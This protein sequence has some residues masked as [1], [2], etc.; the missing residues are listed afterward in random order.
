MQIFNMR[1]CQIANLKELKTLKFP[2]IKSLNVLGNPGADELGANLKSY[3]LIYMEDYNLEKLK[4][5]FCKN[6]ILFGSEN[7]SM[8]FISFVFPSILTK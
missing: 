5:I 1:E 6:C 3:C 2:K 8:S 7:I 4:L